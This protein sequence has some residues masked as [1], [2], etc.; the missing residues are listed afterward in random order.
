MTENEF[1]KIINE[2]Y[3]DNAKEVSLAIKYENSVMFEYGI[4]TYED[5]LRR[6]PEEAEKIRQ[7]EKTPR[8][9]VKYNPISEEVYEELDDEY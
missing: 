8:P 3:D 2:T 9:P 5:I 7:Q 6:I 4:L 1:W